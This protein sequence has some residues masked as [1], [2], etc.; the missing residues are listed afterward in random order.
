MADFKDRPEV[1]EAFTRLDDADILGAM[2]QWTRCEDPV[3]RELSDRLLNRRLFKI[4]F[5]PEALSV[6]QRHA[7]EAKIQEAFGYTA[8]ESR[9]F[10]LEGTASNATY[11][12]DKE[13]IK[14][15]KK[16]GSVVPLSEASEILPLSV[17][18]HTITRPFVCWPK[19][20][21][22]ID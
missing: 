19:G 5:L 12:S 17:Y 2:K 9:H 7:L 21:A 8:E 4:K 10:V 3:L 20:I 16:N 6:T 11:K 18:S 14:I 13:E 15:L 1:L 22:W